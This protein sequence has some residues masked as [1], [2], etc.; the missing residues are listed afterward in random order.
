MPAPAGPPPDVLDLLVQEHLEV[1][2][3]LNR[4]RMAEVAARRDLADRLIAHLVR[5]SVVEELFVYPTALDYLVDGGAFVAHDLAE[6]EQIEGML[7]ELEGLDAGDEHF[8]GVVRDLQAS[9]A[10]HFADEEAQQFAQLR[11]AVPADELV[12]L[13]EGLE[14]AER[15]SATGAGPDSPAGVVLREWVGGGVGMVD[16]VRDALSRRPPV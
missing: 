16:R 11:F 14:R 10:Q 2:D 8:L 1:Q 13:R 12:R 6:H 9:L 7:R 15:L 3:L 4:L 5:H